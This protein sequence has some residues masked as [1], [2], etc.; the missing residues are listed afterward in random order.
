MFAEGS[1]NLVILGNA[2]ATLV[3]ATSP[4]QI[5]AACRG[6]PD[7]RFVRQIHARLKLFLVSHGYIL[8]QFQS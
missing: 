3:S 8:N 6:H 4:E 5:Q 7:E 2:R 1:S